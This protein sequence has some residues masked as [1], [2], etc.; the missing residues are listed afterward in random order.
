MKKTYHLCLS[1]GDESIFR[2]QEDY[3]MGFNYFA[4]ALYKTD[5]TG[6][7]ESFM[8]THTHQAVQTSAPEEFMYNF[9]RP[10]SLYFNHK[11]QRTGRLGENNH[12]TMEVIGY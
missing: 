3:H 5:S 2:D 9:R 11:Y 7:A 10:Y 12:F 1:G 4:L 6:L 8:S